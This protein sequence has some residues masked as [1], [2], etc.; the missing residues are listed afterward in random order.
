MGVAIAVQ[1]R[2]QFRGDGDCEHSTSKSIQTGRARNVDGGIPQAESRPF[3]SVRCDGGTPPGGTP[4]G[5]TP[6]R[7]CRHGLQGSEFRRGIIVHSQAHAIRSF[8]GS[9]FWVEGSTSCLHRVPTAA[10]QA[11]RAGTL[12]RSDRSSSRL[13]FGT[14]SHFTDAFLAAS[15]SQRSRFPV[16]AK[17]L[18]I[19]Q[20][21][22]IAEQMITRGGQTG[23]SHR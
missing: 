10:P 17:D 15:G 19:S 6:P 22:S 2:W 11:W 8:F 9:S 4:P 20:C 16:K 13:T 1:G 21:R 7:S 18:P 5:G 12:T 23:T 14:T 3:W